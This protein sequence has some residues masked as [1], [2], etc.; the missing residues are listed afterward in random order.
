[1]TLL[2]D[3][4]TVEE[5][6]AESERGVQLRLH[7]GD[8]THDGDLLIFLGLHPE[9][10]DMADDIDTLAEGTVHLAERP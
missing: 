6:D 9:R 3:R 2:D 7:L 8:R 4:V 10:L 5:F 1:M